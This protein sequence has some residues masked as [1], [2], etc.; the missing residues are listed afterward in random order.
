MIDDGLTWL[1]V[2]QNRY[3][4]EVDFHR[5]REMARSLSFSAV[6]ALHDVQSTEDVGSSND[7]DK[8][9]DPVQSILT[10]MGALN[11]KSAALLQYISLTITALTILGVDVFGKSLSIYLYVYV[12]VYVACAFLL[13]RCLNIMGPIHMRL[14]SPKDYAKAAISELLL[15][16][17]IFIFVLRVTLVL[18]LVGATAL[19]LL[20]F[21]YRVPAV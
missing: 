2:N 14:G 1:F 19:L 17:A 3:T 12:G 7:E 6:R 11:D 13:L 21:I 15:R 18:A 16:R 10:D 4:R 8:R 5:D 20:P 9:I